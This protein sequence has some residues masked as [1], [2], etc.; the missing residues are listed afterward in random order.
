MTELVRNMFLT[1]V[2]S[3]I[4]CVWRIYESWSGKYPALLNISRTGR[5]ALM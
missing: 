1:E 4:S 3:S 2:Y 5:V